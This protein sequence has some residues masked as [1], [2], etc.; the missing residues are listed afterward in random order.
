MSKSLKG[1]LASGNKGC[2]SSK[3]LKN[4]E[5]SGSNAST[6]TSLAS[7]ISRSQGNT[8][9]ING[10]GGGGGGTTIPDPLQINNLIVLELAAI[11]NALIGGT[12]NI[13]NGALVFNNNTI[14][15]NGSIIVNP[16][17]DFQIDPNLVVNGDYTRLNTTETRIFDRVPVIGYIDPNGI[18]AIDNSDRGFEFDYVTTDGTDFFYNRGFFGY[19]K[20]RDRFVGWK[21]AIIDGGTFGND[22]NYQRTGAELNQFDLDVIYTSE[23][24]NMDY[25]IGGTPNFDIRIEASSELALRSLLE[26]HVTENITVVA[27]DDEIHTLGIS[28]FGFTGRYL[29]QLAN[30]PSCNRIELGDKTG[31][32][33]SPGAYVNHDTLVELRTCDA[34]SLIDIVSADDLDMTAKNTLNIESTNGTVALDASIGIFARNK[35]STFLISSGTPSTGGYV[36]VRARKA[37]TPLPGNFVPGNGDIYIEATDEIY[38][39]ANDPIT[40]Q[41]GAYVQIIPTLRV[42]QITSINTTDPVTFLTDLAIAPG[43]ALLTDEIHENTTNLTISTTFGGHDIIMS[44]VD[45]ISVTAT[46]TLNLAATNANVNISSPSGNVVT[47]A[48]TDV[49]IRNAGAAPAVGLGSDVYIG[50]DD[51]VIIRSGNVPVNPGYVGLLVESIMLSAESQVAIVSGSPIIPASFNSAGD[52]LICADDELIL[53]SDVDIRA[54]ADILVVPGQR[55]LVNTINETNTNMTIQTLGAGRNINIISADDV[56]IS[57]LGGTGDIFLT[58]TGNSI[59]TNSDIFDA[60]TTVAGYSRLFNNFNQVIANSTSSYLQSQPGGGGQASLVSASAGLATITSDNSIRVTAGLYSF[61][62]AGTNSVLMQASTAPTNVGGQIRSFTILAGNS[63]PTIPAL[64]DDVFIGGTDQV[65]VRANNDIELYPGAGD[66]V[67]VGSGTDRKLFARS[68]NNDVASNYWIFNA[69]TAR[70]LDTAAVP[71]VGAV[72]WF[73]NASRFTLTASPGAGTTFLSHNGGTVSWQSATSSDTLQN[74]YN[75]SN[76]ARINLSN[77]NAGIILRDSGSFPSATTVTGSIFQVSDSGTRNYLN[78]NKT[79]SSTVAVT[80]GQQAGPSTPVDFNA[81]STNVLLSTTTGNISLSAGSSAPV[82]GGGPPDI[83]LA[84][85]D[86]LFIRVGPSAPNIGNF[87]RDMWATT[88]SSIILLASSGSSVNISSGSNSNMAMLVTNTQVNFNNGSGVLN[89]AVIAASSSLQF[90]ASGGTPTRDNV[91]IVSGADTGTSNIPPVNDSVVLMSG[92]GNFPS[93]L[94]SNSLYF[95]TE[96]SG[97]MIFRTGLTSQTIN[98]LYSPPDFL[99]SS[100]SDI[101]LLAGSSA[102]IT[103]PFAGAPSHAYIGGESNV[104]IRTGTGA[105]AQAAPVGFSTSGDILISAPINRTIWL[106]AGKVTITG[107]LDPTGLLI[108]QQSSSS[109][110][111]AGPPASSVTSKGL[112]W[113]KND[114]PTSLIYT[115]SASKDTPIVPSSVFINGGIFTGTL[116]NVTYDTVIGNAVLSWQLPLISAVSAG[117]KFLVIASN[118]TVTVTRQGADS[119]VTGGATVT[120]V[121]VLSGTQRTFVSSGTN[122]YT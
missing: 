28:G 66:Q 74:I 24:K 81:F 94:T 52:I 67:I 15:G 58:A 114:V 72:P 82:I 63:P 18:L 86:D 9:I 43:S 13:G 110:I 22:Q 103:P 62:S 122:W 75:N 59:V 93:V 98:G 54:E 27:T 20:D 73:N 71:N 17:I 40:I 99:V 78:V 117:R 95:I 50:G 87:G 53:C 101:V 47:T 7:F 32:G 38:L 57:A 85:E 8:I 30:N 25:L 35:N 21:R 49:I 77:P 48:A 61:P 115:N 70:P 14:T 10:G 92:V 105:T 60:I 51:S 107:L 97:H 104:Y 34:V 26:S 56:N 84:A 106:D 68:G 88:E 116:G 91:I 79:A 11:Q 4:L 102:A 80:V 3:S 33:F 120:S 23:I 46:N 119:I 19:D 83:W 5:A 111:L 90:T 64:A 6:D 89:N 16:T 39:D 45:N 96:D 109:T 37:A 42:D 1:N 100:S 31:V 29:V 108:D 65:F 113:V 69:N 112:I 44:S 118:G 121:A 36:D 41:S 55:I 2:C 76:P 12:L